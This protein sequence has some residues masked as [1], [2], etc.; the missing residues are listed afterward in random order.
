M[1]SLAAPN[2]RRYLISEERSASL[3]RIVSASERA[4]A[5][6][7][8]A[9]AYSLVEMESGPIANNLAFIEYDLVIANV[10]HGPELGIEELL[11]TVFNVFRES[12]PVADCQRDLLSL[13]QT[14][15]PCLLERQLLLDAV[16]AHDDRSVLPA[17]DFPLFAALKRFSWTPPRTTPLAIL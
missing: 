5:R 9:A 4:S 1:P 3:F 14:E 13:E 7:D 11:P 12:D 10:D 16:L 2:R 8:R 6:S 15:F 17:E